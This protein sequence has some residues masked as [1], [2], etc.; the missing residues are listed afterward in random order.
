[1]NE[2][3]LRELLRQAPL[4][5]EEE[6]ERDGL[7]VIRQAFAERSARPRRTM[8]RLAVALAGAALLGLLLLTPAGAQVRDW[9]D[10]VLTPGI[11]DAKPA[12]TEV[13]GGGSLLVQ[14]AS[15]SWVVQPDGSRRLLGRYEEST[16]SPR[17]LFVGATGGHTLSAIEPGGT[18]HWSLSAAAPVADPRWSPSGFRIAYRAGRALR[19]VGANGTGDSLLAPRIAPPAPAW[20]A[21]GPHLL[22]YVTA[23]GELRI[24]NSDS[25][26]ILASADALPGI[27][28]LGWSRD[29]T[30]LEASPDALRLREVAVSKLGA[31]LDLGDTRRIAVPRAARLWGAAISPDG[32]T[33]AAL[34]AFAA[35]ESRPPRSEVV[36]VDAD[37]GRPRAALRRPGHL[38]GPTWSPDGR[39]LLVGWRD[40]DQ[41]LFIPASGRGRVR[42]VGEIS[43]QFAPGELGSASFPKIEGWCC[44]ATF[45]TP[46]S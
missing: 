38:S 30:L 35:R 44:P 26:E 31:G 32:A 16:W 45:G 24:A 4:P 7:R 11:H 46:P 8:P 43:T 3:R 34:F 10:D 17:G 12:L 2:D 21:Q 13:P 23:A 27:A 39:L 41:L 36:L 1:M 40:A 19:V 15:G 22:A 28:T 6:A 20:S 14:S 42:A 9:I 18:V 25:A 33:V 29:G 5:G 37:S